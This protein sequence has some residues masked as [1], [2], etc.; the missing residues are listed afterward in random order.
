M[1]KL[2]KIRAFI[3]LHQKST[4]EDIKDFLIN[5]GVDEQKVQSNRRA[6]LCL[7]VVLGM[8]FLDKL[9]LYYINCKQT[10]TLEFRPMSQSVD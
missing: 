6:P 3:F 8:K 9:F 1:K 7:F 2:R 5:A 10:A 4:L